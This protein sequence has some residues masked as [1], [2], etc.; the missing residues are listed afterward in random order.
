MRSR[1][2]SGLPSSWFRPLGVRTYVRAERTFID[3]HQARD[4]IARSRSFAEA[5]RILALRSSGGNWRTLKHYA[6]D[7]WHIPTDHF[8][9]RAAQRAALERQH[10]RPIPLTDVLV[11]HSTFSRG[12]LKARLYAEGYKQRRC[13]ICGQEDVWRGRRMSLILDHI[14]GVATDNRL[15]NLRIVCPNC[16]ATLDTHCGRNMSHYRLCEGCGIT[17][18]A[19]HRAQRYCSRR[20]AAH[21]DAALRSQGATRRVERPPFEQLLHE[22]AALGYSGVG[23]RYGVSDNAIRKW[24]RRYEQ[25]VAA[26]AATSSS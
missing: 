22:I 13:E 15:E 8:D 16:A 26:A 2:E 25:E 12:H 11:E 6:T 3:E 17:F 20:C 9:P 19:G 14:N 7:I 23:R 4:A 5:L 18:K 21:G 24:V 1:F 10:R